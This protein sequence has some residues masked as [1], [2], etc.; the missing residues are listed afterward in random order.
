LGQKFIE[1]VNFRRF[2]VEIDVSYSLNSENGGNQQAE[3]DGNAQTAIP[4]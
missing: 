1:Y 3:D 4:L 2:T